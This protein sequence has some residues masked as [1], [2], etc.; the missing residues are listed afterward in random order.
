MRCLAGKGSLSDLGRLNR[1]ALL[2]LSG[3]DGEPFY[4]VLTGLEGGKASLLFES[5]GGKVELRWFGE[6]KVLWRPPAGYRDALRPGSSAAAVTRL[7]ELLAAAGLPAPGM[8]DDDVYDPALAE[9]V[10]AFQ[11]RSGLEPD[12]IAGP[13]TF[14]HLNSA[15][16]V[17][18]PR[19]AP[20]G[21]DG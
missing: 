9:E 12:G 13:L 19:L 3:T 1:P 20:S 17:E 5:G 11:Q 15:V 21:G 7:R 2:R 10:S 16:R 8:G 18:G 6:Y 4:A 14:I